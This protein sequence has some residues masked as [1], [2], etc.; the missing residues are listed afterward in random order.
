V[1]EAGEAAIGLGPLAIVMVETPSNPLNTLVD[2]AMVRRVAD[3]IGARQSG[4]RRSLRVTTRSRP[5]FQRP[6][7]HGAGRFPL[8][9]DQ[10]CRRPLRLDRRRRARFSG[11]AAADP[12]A[13]DLRSA[14]NSTRIPAGCWAAQ[15]ETLALRMDRGNRNAE[16]V[17]GMLASHPSVSRVHYLG[18][19]PEGRARD[20]Y[21]AQAPRRGRRSHST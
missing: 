12:S 17:A 11:D 9:A 1:R 2:L 8:L 7:E 19:L 3:E 6:L 5:A 14:R 18:H 4:R 20:V 13:C 21:A 16:V 10:I 15:W